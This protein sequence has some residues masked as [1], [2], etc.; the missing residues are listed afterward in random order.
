MF[1]EK[2]ILI[3]L[4]TI[5]MAFALILPSIHAQDIV[6]GK[7]T[8]GEEKSLDVQAKLNNIFFRDNLNDFLKSKKIK[9]IIELVNSIELDKD[10]RAGLVTFDNVEA[11][12]IFSD[13]SALRGSHQGVLFFAPGNDGG[14]ILDE[15][16]GFGVNA[17]SSPN[18]LAFNQTAG[19]PGGGLA[20]LPEIIVFPQP[21]SVVNIDIASGG[22]AGWQLS[23]IAISPGGVVDSDVF[24]TTE[25]WSTRT[26][27]GTG[28]RAVIILGT[29]PAFVLDNIGFQ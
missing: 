28:I 27:S 6:D 5:L 9:E 11:P 3:L 21:V 22:S 12:C 25:N 24:T 14:A 10:V 15:C 4:T 8:T 20:K 23:L 29:D 26:L 16:G 7:L 19:Y 18:F 13:T 2:R 1:N 17:A